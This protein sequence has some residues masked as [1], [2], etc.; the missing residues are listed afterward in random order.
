M[1]H[2]FSIFQST[3]NNQ[4]YD[5]YLVLQAKE[6][7]KAPGIKIK[8]HLKRA[9]QQQAN[10]ETTDFFA[11]LAE[12]GIDA[13]QQEHPSLVR[14]FLFRTQAYYADQDTLF[15]AFSSYMARQKELPSQKS[16]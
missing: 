9:L 12:K 10:R 5:A 2:D 8:A 13:T 11:E 4:C 16:R 15:E 3:Y 6:Q 14:E 7:E 1:D